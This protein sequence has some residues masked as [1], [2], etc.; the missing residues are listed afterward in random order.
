MHRGSVAVDEMRRTLK[1]TGCRIA[2][3]L[4]AG[5]IE[6]SEQDERHDEH[7]DEHQSM[8]HAVSHKHIQSSICHLQVAELLSSK[9]SPVSRLW[10]TRCLLRLTQLGQKRTLAYL[11]IL[12]KFLP[13]LSR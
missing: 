13:N 2:H 9:A 10:I 12:N 7:H 8:K 5:I 11:L 1:L 4:F 6:I 3:W